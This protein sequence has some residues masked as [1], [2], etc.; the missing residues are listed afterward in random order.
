MPRVICPIRISAERWE[1]FYR[2]LIQSLQATSLDGRTVQLPATALRPF[3]DSN[4]VDGI[5]MIDFSDSG[6][7]IALHRVALRPTG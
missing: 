4:G 6:K 3:V 2:G 7:L 1:P 5:F